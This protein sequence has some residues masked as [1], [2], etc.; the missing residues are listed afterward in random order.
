MNFNDEIVQ[1]LADYGGGSGV[2][3]FYL[4]EP[5]IPTVWNNDLTL[6]RQAHRHNVVPKA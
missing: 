2:G 5:G 6:L 1:P 3:G 4:G